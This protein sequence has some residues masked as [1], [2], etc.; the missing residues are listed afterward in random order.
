MGGLGA[1]GGD[2]RQQLHRSRR[3][4]AVLWWERWRW[5]AWGAPVRGVEGGGGLILRREGPKRGARGARGGT[6]SA[7]SALYWLR[8]GRG[9]RSRVPSRRREGQSEAE[10]WLGSASGH[11]RAMRG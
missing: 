3:P 7:T 4:A 6:G 10:A 1:R 11:H 8:G 5:P 9:G 2:R